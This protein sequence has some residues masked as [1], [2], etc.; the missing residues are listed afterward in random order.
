MTM[1]LETIQ[2][3]L[4]HPS[5]LYEDLL[6]ALLF[7]F[8]AWLVGRALG[9]GFQRVLERPKHIPSDPTAIRFLSQLARLGVYLFAFVSYAHLIPELRS[10]GTAWLA[11][12]GVVSVVLGLAAQNTLG[13]LIAGISL[14]LYRPFN[15]GDRVQVTAPTGLETGV[16]ESLNLGYTILVTPDKRRIVIPNSAMAS[17]TSVNLSMMDDRKKCVVPFRL[18]AEADVEKA[19][20][21]LQELARQHP[22]MLEL[23]GCP[24]TFLGGSSVTLSLQAFCKDPD[25]AEQFKNDLFESAR[26]RLAKEGITLY[27]RPSPK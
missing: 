27:S 3:K 26:N 5:T 16:V 18:S 10:L 2:N 13:N 4:L 24:V 6:L 11:S 22:K 23:I 15:L 25:A 12:V 17:Q 19:R 20:A 21:I 9:L 8:V 7:A 1:D 14:L